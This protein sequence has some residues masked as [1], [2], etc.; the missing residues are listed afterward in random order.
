MLYGT[1][2]VRY[3]RTSRSDIHQAVPLFV[4]KLKDL[5]DIRLS[6]H[7]SNTKG[8]CIVHLHEPFVKC[9]T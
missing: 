5:P 9:G 8:S 6:M 1:M 3:E 4:V 7:L 2:G